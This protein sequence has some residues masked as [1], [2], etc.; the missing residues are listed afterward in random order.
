MPRRFPRWIGSP[1]RRAPPPSFS[2]QQAGDSLFAPSDRNDQGIGWIGRRCGKPRGRLARSVQGMSPELERLG[3][4][5][6]TPDLWKP[7]AAASRRAAAWVST[8]GMDRA[9]ARTRAKTARCPALRAS[10]LG[11][12]DGHRM[13]GADRAARRQGPRSSGVRGAF[14]VG[15]AR[16]LARRRWKRPPNRGSA[17]SKK[18]SP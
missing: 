17:S 2:A 5:L 14:G 3:R 11:A 9:R 1:A 13:G 10:R 12:R 18:R 15:R 6:I 7:V 8:R 16:T 4:A